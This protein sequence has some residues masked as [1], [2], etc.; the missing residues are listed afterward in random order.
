MMVAYP[1]LGCKNA[2]VWQG[3]D[4]FFCTNIFLIL[5]TE[6][7]TSSISLISHDDYSDY[8]FIF[9][10]HFLKMDSV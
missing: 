4:E 1:E 6:C 8:L 5:D 9:Q 7:N 2:G 3:A 10:C